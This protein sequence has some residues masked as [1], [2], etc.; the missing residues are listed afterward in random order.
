MFNLQ[1]YG[2]GHAFILAP[3]HVC[4]E[5]VKLHDLKFNSRKIIIEEAKNSTKHF[6]E[7]IIYKHFSKWRGKYA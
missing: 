7:W 3:S 6:S 2:N 5:L 1:Q 4:D